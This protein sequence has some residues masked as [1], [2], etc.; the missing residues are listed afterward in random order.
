MGEK[1]TALVVGGGISG[2]SAAIELA[3]HGF[4][5]RIVEREPVWHALGS[6]I[7]LMGPALRAL[8]RMGVLD[9]C[10]ENGVGVDEFR[11]CGPDSE[12]VEVIP[13]PPPE[14]GLPG[15]LGMTRPELHRILAAY[16]DEKG[17]AVTLGVSVADFENRP[18]GVTVQFSDGEEGSYDL[19]VAADGFHSATRAALFGELTPVFRNQGVFRAVL[20]RP[21][22]ADAAFYF[23][24]P[25]A[26]GLTLTGEDSLYMYCDV[27][28]AS[29]ERL[30]QEDLPAL[31]R[32]H[33]GHLSGMAGDLRD[34]IEDPAKV[35][36]RPMETLLLPA[37]TYRDRVV[38]I[39]DAAHTPT[40]QLAAGGAM[41]LEDSLALAEELARADSIDAGLQAYSERRFGRCEFVVD[42]SARLSA[43][44]MDPA[45]ADGSGFTAAMGKSVAVL[46][47][48]F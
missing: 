16:A 9:R 1:R 29:A 19:L 41:C 3:R 8:N 46:A 13:L 48:E 25:A 30:P 2:T 42:A 23:V 14:A 10:F 5:A 11:I 15:M 33:L 39:G 34:Q 6:G 7:T 45:D 18:D 32:G 21:A 37:P 44:Q 35:D 26:S 27:P 17:V 28:A 43:L 36:Y 20:P 31:M 38:V 12:V 4:E 24:G 40:P 47:Q 22:Q